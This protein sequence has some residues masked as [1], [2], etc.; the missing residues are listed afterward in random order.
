MEVSSHALDQ[1]RTNDVH[2]HTAL[3]TNLSRD[4]LDYHRTLENYGEAKARLFT[5]HQVGRA[6]IN[7]DDVWGRE[8]TKRWKAYHPGAPLLTFSLEHPADLQAEVY[9]SPAGLELKL[10]IPCGSDTV[11]LP[12]L[13]GRFNASNILGVI[14]VWLH[15]G[16]SWKQILTLLPHVRPVLGRMNR[17]GG[18]ALR[19]PTIIVDYAHTP[20]AL[21]KVLLAL[22]GLRKSTGGKLWCIFGAGGDRDPGKRPLMGAVAAEHA[23]RVVITTDNPRSEK[24]AD[25]AEDVYVGTHAISH[26]N[27]NIEVDRRRAII[28]TLTATAPEDI[29]LIAGKGHE[30]YQEVAGIRTHFSDAEEVESWLRLR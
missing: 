11:L 13:N 19:A 28:T 1:R 6:V 2:F 26:Q 27:V 16:V 29:V 18:E 3:F 17:F 12:H 30:T 22:H 7:I 24:P 20:D 21:E 10:Q 9:D 4:H 15:L 8:L 5:N 23:D 25:I 14:G